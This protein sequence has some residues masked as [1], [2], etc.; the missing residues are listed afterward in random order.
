MLSDEKII[1]LEGF[2]DFISKKMPIDV[3]N[4]FNTELNFNTKQFFLAWYFGGEKVSNLLNEYKQA[5]K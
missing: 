3:K 1:E 2:F 4:R 5:N